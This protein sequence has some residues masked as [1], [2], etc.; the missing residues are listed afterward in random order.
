VCLLRTQPEFEVIGEFSA[1]HELIKQP[2]SYSPDVVLADLNL[3]TIN[4]VD[5][6]NL[7]RQ[8][9]PSQRI[10]ILSDNPS[11]LLAL[12]CFRNGALGYA[13]RLED[14][15]HLV[16]AIHSV[17]LGH[18]YLSQL[19]ID[20][21]LDA[22]IAGKEFEKS[23]DDRISAREREILQLIAEGRSNSE[24]GKSLVISTRTVETHRNNL[25]RKLGLSSQ[26][27]IIRYAVK[28]GLIS[29]E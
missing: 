4:N 29:I 10:L 18:R 15:D 14:F 2:S 6:S 12:R 1:G 23:V 22:A 28:Q 8:W 27:E 20:Q 9:N 3:P 11:P 24:I 17:Y 13:V 7:I 21:M 16:Q 5:P 26:I 25:M 19:I